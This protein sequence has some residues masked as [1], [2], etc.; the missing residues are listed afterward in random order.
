MR[1]LIFVAAAGMLAGCA[2]VP[3]SRWETGDRLL[4][5]DPDFRARVE[6]VCG[7]GPSGIRDRCIFDN[8]GDE[9][10]AR[11]QETT[12]VYAGEVATGVACVALLP[13]CMIA[14]AAA[15]DGIGDGFDG[16][17]FQ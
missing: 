12:D 7:H 3:E 8:F 5:T 11:A 13:L 6:A 9:L 14:M 17:D 10:A 1:G 2:T 16:L 15:F 4:K